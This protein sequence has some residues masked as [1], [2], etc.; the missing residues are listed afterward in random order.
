MPKWLEDEL[1]KKAAEKGLKGK[2]RKAYIY[3]T[4]A[5]YKKR[6]KEKEQRNS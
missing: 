4:L 3:G 6:K 5:L 2:R 1:Q